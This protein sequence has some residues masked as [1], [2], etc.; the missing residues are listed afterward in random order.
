VIRYALVCEHDHP[1]E[2]WFGASS[3]YDDQIARGLVECPFCASTG[4]RK[5]IMAPAVRGAKKTGEVPPPGQVHTRMMEAMG[6]VRR[7]VEANFDYVGDRFAR[8][9]RDIHDGESEARGIYGEA[10]PKEVKALIEDGIQV[11]P[12][13]P[14]ATP[15]AKT[16][17]N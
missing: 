4:V 7:H 15:K 3:D 6:K 12:M 10:S 1:F 13:P 9:A 14:A 16:E 11:A 5:Q 17:V 8:E 2:A